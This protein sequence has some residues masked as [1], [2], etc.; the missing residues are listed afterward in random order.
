VQ[1]LKTFAHASAMNMQKLFLL[2]VVLL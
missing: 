1:I 2:R